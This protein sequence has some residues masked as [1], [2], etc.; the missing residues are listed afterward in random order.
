MGKKAKGAAG[1]A[2]TVTVQTG[3]TDVNMLPLLKKPIEAVGKEIGVIGS[4]WGSSCPSSDRNKIFKCIVSDFSIAH[5][6]DEDE[7]PTK[8]FQLSEMGVDGSGG[9]SVPFW[10]VY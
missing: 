2:K 4:H 5:R 9:N 7:P 6:M 8:A 10:M 3:L 1:K